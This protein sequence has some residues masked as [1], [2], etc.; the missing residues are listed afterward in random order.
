MKFPESGLN[1]CLVADRFE[2]LR[3]CNARLYKLYKLY[4][5]YQPTL[6]LP[7]LPKTGVDLNSTPSKMDQLSKM[8]I[9]LKSKIRSRNENHL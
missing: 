2:R 6:A 3:V 5:P 8:L 4:Q 1:A 7:C 9:I